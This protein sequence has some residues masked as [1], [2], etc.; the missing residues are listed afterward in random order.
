M[1]VPIIPAFCFA[2]SIFSGRDDDEP[3]RTESA[4]LDSFFGKQTENPNAK[5]GK[6]KSLQEYGLSGQSD[7]SNLTLSDPQALDAER[8]YFKSKDPFSTEN[9]MGRVNDLLA[10]TE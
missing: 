2:Q 9:R 3:V 5:W 4:L 7:Q 10:P 8:A 1:L 6:F